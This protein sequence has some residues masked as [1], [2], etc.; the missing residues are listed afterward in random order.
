VTPL[1]STLNVCRVG[2]VSSRAQDPL[3]A[4]VLISGGIH[5]LTKKKAIS[6]KTINIDENIGINIDINIDTNI[7]KYQ[8]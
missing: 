1:Q 6:T 2:S 3:R 4:P 5:R 8:Y 7:D